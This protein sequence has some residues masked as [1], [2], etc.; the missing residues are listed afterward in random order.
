MKIHEAI[1]EI[2]EEKHYSQEAMAHVLGLTQSQYCR[3]ENGAVRFVA[4]EIPMLA[5]ELETPIAEIY[6]EEG[7]PFTNPTQNG[8]NFK[9]KVSMLENLVAKYKA[10]LKEKDEMITFL[11]TN[12]PKA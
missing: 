3:R 10:L 2:R 6:G 4:E 12:N 8:N 5:K 9:Q 7:H 1:K 11:K